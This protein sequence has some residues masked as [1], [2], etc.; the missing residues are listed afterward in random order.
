M[1]PS[2]DKTFLEPPSALTHNIGRP[3][4]ILDIGLGIG[5]AGRVARER[6]AILVGV[7]ASG[8]SDHRDRDAAYDEVIRASLQNDE[9]A[10]KLGARKFDLVYVGKALEREAEP[11]LVLKRLASFLEDG[12]H[13]LIDLPANEA[14]ASKSPATT[15]QNSHAIR[16]VEDANLE[17]MRIAHCDDGKTLRRIAKAVSTF[18]A[19]APPPGS[20]HSIVARKPPKPGKLSLTIGMLSLNESDSVEKM[21]DEIRAVA[22]DAK[23]LLIDSS[24]DNTPE[25]A[26]NKGAR[27][28]RQLPP[29][30]HAPAMHRLMYEAAQESDALI[31]I[32]CDFTYPTSEI[33][34]IREL[35]EA[36][37]DVVN[38]SRTHTYP[39]AMPVAHFLANRFFAAT[40]QAVHGVPTTDVHS[41][42]RGYRSSVIRAFDFNGGG[43]AIPLDTLILPARS[44]YHVVELPISYHNRVGAS[45]LARL[46][47]T[48]WT[49]ARVFA[50]IGEGTRV[51]SGVRYRHVS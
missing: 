18:W 1:E 10:G 2:A 22:P 12:G 25:L 30:G 48:T 32:D 39:E 24:S 9:L 14:E 4:T 46:R 26:R 37:A 33:P 31:Y 6:G 40:A 8:R 11:L 5:D 29:R 35:L 20:G 23:I 28:V 16:I 21:I 3:R 27:V 41:G 38:T 51:R 47:G 15:F 7:D 43:D 34:R 17:V 36:G 49:F 50:A 42:M 13:A 44:H 45:K 19:P